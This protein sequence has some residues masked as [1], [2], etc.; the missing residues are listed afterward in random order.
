LALLV[1]VDQAFFAKDALLVNAEHRRCLEV[2]VDGAVSKD[3]F[4]H[5]LLR[6]I[7]PASANEIRFLHLGNGFA[8]FV[9]FADVALG[10]VYVRRALFGNQMAVFGKEYVEVGPAAITSLVH[11]I[12]GH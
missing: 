7:A 3:L 10:A 2:T 1:D 4:H 11:V 8:A 9:A 6:G 12:T 5:F